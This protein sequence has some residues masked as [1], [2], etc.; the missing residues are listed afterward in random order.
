MLEADVFLRNRTAVMDALLSDPVLEDPA[1]FEL[2]APDPIELSGPGGD[3]PSLA[4]LSENPDLAAPPP[5]PPRGGP[6]AS[7]RILALINGQDLAESAPPELTAHLSE[8]GTRSTEADPEAESPAGATSGADHPAIALAHGIA[9]RALDIVGRLRHPKAAMAI[10]GVIVVVLVLV[11]VLGQTSPDPEQN[12]SYAAALTPSTAAPST[13]TTTAAAGTI[14][15]R[16]VQAHCPPGGTPAMDVVAGP[17]R[18][19]S[20]I[21]AYKVDGQVLTID[22]GRSYQIESIGIVPGWDMVTPDGVDQWTKYRT[23]S[24]VSYL[25]DDANATTY[26]Q[27]TM[28]Q[29]GLVV[30]RMSPV[31]SASRIVVTVLESKGDPSV[32]S[33]ALSSLVITGRG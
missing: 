31:V 29:R 25:F 28:D 9:A 12:N 8:T 24:R 13:T 21:R 3:M 32:N 19:W 10:G 18:A 6:K 11:L 23:A 17:G 33:V 5:P 4:A 20:C 2:G 26:T 7:E 27:R 22:L 1:A 30:T 15:V 16:S 14:Q